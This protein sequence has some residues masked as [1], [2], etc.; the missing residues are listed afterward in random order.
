MSSLIFD[1]M[2][3]YIYL[4][5]FLKNEAVVRKREISNK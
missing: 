3:R 5:H 2:Q 4:V 1:A